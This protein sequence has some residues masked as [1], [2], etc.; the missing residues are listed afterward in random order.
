LKI[1][2]IPYVDMANQQIIQKVKK[3]LTRRINKKYKE[4]AEN[5]FKEPVK[6]IGATLPEQRKIAK[7]MFEEV[8]HLNKKEIFSLAEA[9]LKTGYFDM[10]TVGIDWVRRY[11]KDFKKSDF[12]IFES[13]MKKYINNW[14]WCDDFC[15]HTLA[16]F[17]TMYPEFIKDLKRW[18]RSRN[19]WLRRGS[20]VTF[21][22]PGRNGKFLK[23]IF[24]IAQILLEDQ[25][26]L[27]QKGYGWM[28]KETGKAYPT[29][30]FNFVIKN[31][32]K[33]PRTALRYAI[34]HYPTA[35]R[36]QAMKK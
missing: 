35:K 14:A 31:K 10:G 36:Q 17:I 12:K 2:C 11:K 15:N 18:A 23:D 8:K 6:F 9:M 33:M 28:L 30:V 5:Y 21:V 24:E 20:A 19:R 22:E 27:V 4:G 26:D 34:E 32:L 25:D 13:W 1:F 29:E 16:D 7:E 3:E